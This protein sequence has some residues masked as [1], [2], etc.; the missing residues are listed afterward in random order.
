[1]LN[2]QELECMSNY[3]YGNS[4]LEEIGY[5]E[6]KD[7]YDNQNI[8][9][10]YEIYEEDEHDSWFLICTKK[11][12]SKI[13]PKKRGDIEGYK[14]VNLLKKEFECFHIRP[15]VLKKFARGIYPLFYKNDEIDYKRKIDCE[16]YLKTSKY[17]FCYAKFGKHFLTFS[18]YK[19]IIVM[20]KVNSEE[21]AIMSLLCASECEDKIVNNDL[22][23]FI[24]DNQNYD[25]ELSEAMIL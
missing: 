11:G 4:D 20:N 14:I 3:Y 24:I 22:F 16:E 10:I 8:K 19:N 6:L 18:N 13:V 15:D 2:K 1:M 23:M 17:P 5:I 21:E 7:I 25:H 9:R 12:K